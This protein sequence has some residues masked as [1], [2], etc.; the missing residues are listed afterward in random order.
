MAKTSR[1]SCGVS[2]WVD[3]RQPLNTNSKTTHQYRG[4][5]AVFAALAV[6]AVFAVMRFT[7]FGLAWRAVADDGLAARFMGIDPARVLSVSA[8][9][10][11]SLAGCAGLVILLGYG[12]ANHSM[13]L[14]LSIKAMVA[15]LI[16]GMG[17]PG[18]AVLGALVLVVIET[19]WV[20]T[21][22]GA[23]RDAAVFA[24]LIGLLT[25]APDGLF[26][27]ARK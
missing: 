4:A 10:S 24:I 5:I 17:S 9:M 11:S 21:F 16:G 14:M 1:P 26:G 23:Y 8:V 27:L 7:R 6:G 13:G 19:G 25:L 22:G 2:M 15:A 20:V 12:N 3:G 18:G